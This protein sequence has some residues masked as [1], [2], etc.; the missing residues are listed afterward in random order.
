MIQ[1]KINL[2]LVEEVAVA[3]VTGWVVESGEGYA[4]VVMLAFCIVIIK[5][6]IRW[7]V[8]TRP[9]KCWY[10]DGRF[11]SREFTC[12]IMSILLTRVIYKACPSSKLEIYRSNGG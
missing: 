7:P 6:A 11:K 4:F 8:S 1:P 3:L 2:L 12:V 9:W 5:R 10:F